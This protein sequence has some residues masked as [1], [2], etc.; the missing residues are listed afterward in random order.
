MK[1]T[2]RTSARRGFTL[3]E[4]MV[5][6]AILMSLMGIPAFVILQHKDDGEITKSVN[7]IKS[8]GQ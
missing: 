1:T 4:L 6:I 2:L 8:L 3:I 7:N 5:V